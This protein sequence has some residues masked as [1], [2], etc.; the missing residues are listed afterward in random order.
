MASFL[1]LWSEV[2]R[3]LIV[4]F[5]TVLDM[6]FNRLDFTI[7][8]SDGTSRFLLILSHRSD[9]YIRFRN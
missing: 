5:A 8:A 2:R 1:R 6:F 4:A 7:I 9:A 3:V